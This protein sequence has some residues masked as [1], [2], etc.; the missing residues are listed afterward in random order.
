MVGLG[1]S[2]ADVTRFVDHND[3]GTANLLRVL[4]ESGFE[5]SLV[6]AGSMV[7]YGEGL[8]ICPDHGEVRPA[9]RS[10][11]DLAAGRFEPGCPRCAERVQ[12]VPVT[13][14]AACLPRSVY[15][16]TKLHQ[17]H[18]CEAFAGETGVPLTILRYHNV[19]GARMPADT[20]YAGVASIFRSAYRRGVTPRVFEDGRQLRDFIHVSDV[21]RANMI[22]LRTA[23]PVAGVF[24]I[25]TGE[26]HTVGDMARVLGAQFPDAPDPT[27]TGEYRTGDVR[28]IFASPQRARE[29]LGFSA[30]VGFEDGMARFATDPLRAPVGA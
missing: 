16:A 14:D 25:A 7:V 29:E 4:F 22:A 27:I 11:A 1:T 8:F 21:A 20:P 30:Q 15:A 10:V 26:P 24:N 17:E 23:D 2:F 6:L 12:A 18:L 19:Y 3:S 28:H 13:E 5:G 9:P